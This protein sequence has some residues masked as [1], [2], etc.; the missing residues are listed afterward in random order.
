MKI[1]LPKCLFFLLFPLV[2]WAQNAERNLSSETWS[3]RKKSDTHWLPATVPG[4][5]HT[6]LF[7]NKIIPDPF[8]GSNEK[9]L[10]W[11]ENEDW[12]YQTSFSISIEEANKEQRL[13][14]RKG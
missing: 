3:F 1:R 4:T 5:V 2:F 12:E 10:Q 9:Q 13:G 7:N 8:Y 14:M 11:I 6:D